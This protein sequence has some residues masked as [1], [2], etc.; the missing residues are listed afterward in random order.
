MVVIV[1]ATMKTPSDEPAMITSYGC[2]SLYSFYRQHSPAFAHIRLPLAFPAYYIRSYALSSF[3]F[4]L[5]RAFCCDGAA[6]ERIVLEAKRTRDPVKL[7]DRLIEKMKPEAEA[8][9]VPHWSCPALKIRVAPDGGKTWDCYYRVRKGGPQRRPSL[10]R[11]PD[12]GTEQALRCALDLTAEARQGRDLLDK[13]KQAHGGAVAALIESYLDGKVRNRLRTAVEVERTLKRVLAPIASKSAASVERR[14]LARIFDD[15]AISQNHER[16][17]A[18]ARQMIGSMYRWAIQRGHVERNP[19]EGTATF[20]AGEPRE[21]FLS[22]D[23]IRLLWD[24]LP[25]S[26]IAPSMVAILQLQLCLGARSGEIAGMRVAEI[27]D[28]EWTWMLPAERSKNGSARVTPLIGKAKEIVASRLEDADDLLFL[29]PAGGAADSASLATHLY[30]RRDSFPI[31]HFTAHDLRRTVASQMAA[32]EIPLETTALILG[33]ET[34][35]RSTKTLERHYIHGDLVPRKRRAL[36]AWDER[37]RQ[38]LA[39]AA[40]TSSN[41][42]SLFPVDDLRLQSL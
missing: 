28:K 26:G 13:E 10:G 39:G 23:E 36:R 31:A 3:S 35:G 11:F 14:D 9:Y 30:L 6:T 27:D 33:Q 22:P 29:S 40:P 18:K 25:T 42:T 32:M 12:I 5:N 15:I 16:A 8:Y 38:I 1:L 17:A 24:W 21:R 19:V 41:V 37:L 2:T 4:A 20:S 7:T 34:G